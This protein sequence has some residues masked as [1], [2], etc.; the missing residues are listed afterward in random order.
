VR[1]VDLE[2]MTQ[3]AARIF[4][5]RCIETRVVFDAALGRDVR[6]ATFRVHRAVKGVTGD[7]VTVRTLAV[8]GNDADAAA[9]VPVYRAGDEVVLFLYGE[10]ASGLSATVGLGQGRF[11]VLADKQGRSLALNDFGNRNL[12]T[13]LRPEAR[14]RLEAR[15]ATAQRAATQRGDDLEPSVLLDAAEALAG[16]ER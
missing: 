1:L 14:A 2:Q 4:S 7:T 8:E 6:V 3:R 5:G 13:G 10:S 12:F 9:G 11:R 16:A 15:S